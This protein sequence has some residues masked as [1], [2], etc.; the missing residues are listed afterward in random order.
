[1]IPDSFF[2]VQPIVK[3]VAKTWDVNP[4]LCSLSGLHAWW[5]G[6]C[7]YW[8]MGC[9]GVGTFSI[10]AVP[11]L[12]WLNLQ[13]PCC[14]RWSPGTGRCECRADGRGAQPFSCLPGFPRA[15]AVLRKAWKDL[16]IL[17]RN[18]R[19]C[20]Q[21]GAVST[22]TWGQNIANGLNWNDSS[23]GRGYWIC[24]DSALDPASLVCL[25]CGKQHVPATKSSHFRCCIHTML[26]SAA[27][28][29]CCEAP[30]PALQSASCWSSH[31]ALWVSASK[32]RLRTPYTEW[33]SSASVLWLFISLC[34]CPLSWERKGYLN[35][36][37][38]KRSICFLKIRISQIL[39]GIN[40]AEGL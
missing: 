22:S 4:V 18:H 26:A 10:C 3:A 36:C 2:C 29:I 34:Y 12:C 28:P 19:Q 40:V 14:L 37:M 24:M 6:S 20:K 27:D 13:I 21:S 35:P 31:S 33:F 7:R 23:Q 39:F 38:H 25:R 16:S 9:V 15:V 8:G 32:F 1:M 11:W 17:P 5:M 30:A